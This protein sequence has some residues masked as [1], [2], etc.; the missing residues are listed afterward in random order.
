MLKLS[1]SSFVSFVE[2]KQIYRNH[3][4]VFVQFIDTKYSVSMIHCCVY[5]TLS[6]ITNYRMLNEWAIVGD[7]STMKAQHAT[8]I[9]WRIICLNQRLLLNKKKVILLTTLGHLTQLLQSIRL[10]W[11]LK[12]NKEDIKRRNYWVRV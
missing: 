5:F 1:L 9:S 2:S 11:E 10:Q 3:E 8:T 4:F 6:M 12:N 7:L